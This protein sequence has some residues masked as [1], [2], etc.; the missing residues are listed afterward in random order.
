MITRRYFAIRPTPRLT[1]SL[2][3]FGI[4]A[5]VAHSELLERSHSSRLRTKRDDDL[6]LLKATYWRVFLDQEFTGT[7]EERDELAR[8]IEL[9]G[10]DAFWTVEIFDSCEDLDDLVADLKQGSGTGGVLNR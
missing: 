7:R 6:A 3:R 8:R 1:E 2:E 9:E 10:F 5:D 4:P